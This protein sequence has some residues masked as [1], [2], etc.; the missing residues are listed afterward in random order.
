MRVAH[1]EA[2][3]RARVEE[4][5]SVLGL[6]SCGDV[7][8][9]NPLERGIS[10][11]EARRLS[12]GVGVADLE[13]VRLLLLDEPTTGLDSSSAAEVMLLARRLAGTADRRAVVASVHQPSPEMFSLFDKAR[14]AEFILIA[15]KAAA[16]AA[17][18]SATSRFEEFSAEISANCAPRNTVL[19]SRAN[20]TAA[21]LE[22]NAVGDVEY[23]YEDAE[24]ETGASEGAGREMGLGGSEHVVEQES[25]L[26]VGRGV[27]LLK[28]EGSPTRDMLRALRGQR[29]PYAVGF[30]AQVS[31]V[32]GRS[33]TVQ[34]R[35]T[36][37]LWALIVKNTF[38]GVLTA[39]VF[40]QE[41]SVRTD[42]ALVD[43]LMN[44][45]TPK[46][47]NV[48]GI[49][50]FGMLYGLTGHLQAIPDIFEWKRH[51]ERERAAGMYS[52][53]VYWLVSSTVHLPILLAGFVVYI[54]VCYWPLG[55]PA[56][57][58]KF[59]I[60]AGASLA[61]TLLGYSLA[62]TLSAALATPQSAFATWPLL[63]VTA[64]NFAGFTVRLPAV[65]VWFRWLCDVSFCRWVFQVST[66]LVNMWKMRYATICDAP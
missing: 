5:L 8:V 51:S 33:W 48:M 23:L 32:W 11:G 24:T 42:E 38:V 52:T 18:A 12:V 1:S 43:P 34:A 13:S 45:V 66:V 17:A 16:A 37:S 57:V 64:A 50:Y 22:S 40:W 15:A 26:G 63:L 3:R 9:G 6:E 2:H 58:T 10:G 7:R 29:T 4:L 53:T 59:C 30:W 65:R 25:E 14:R 55:L 41:G 47:S 56:E 49:L 19:D 54:N 46:A 28:E 61:S 27:L 31:A 20:S 21:A 44:D 36:D 60:F 35:R 39:S 62:Q